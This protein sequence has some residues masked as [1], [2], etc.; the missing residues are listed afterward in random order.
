M[1]HDDRL[2]CTSQHLPGGVRR[3]TVLV[4]SDYRPLNLGYAYDLSADGY[5]VYTAVTCT[6]VPRVLEQ[7]AVECV[8]AIVF[9]SLVHGW[10]HREAEGRPEGITEATDAEWQTR[11]IREVIGIVSQR[12]SAPP[13]VL[14]ADG[15]LTPGWYDS[16]AEALAAAGIEYL[17][18]RSSDPHSI[19][20]MLR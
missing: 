15:M 16:T 6:D 8:D 14:I 13:L 4:V 11:N 17:T 9:A 18:Y 19:V 7:F 1:I 10:H 3:G 12:Q 2:P 20:A 5:A